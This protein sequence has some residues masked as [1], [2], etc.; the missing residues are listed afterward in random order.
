MKKVLLLTAISIGLSSHAMADTPYGLTPEDAKPL[1]SMLMFLSEDEMAD[2]MWFTYTMPATANGRPA[3]FPSTS[4]NANDHVMFI[5]TCADGSNEAPQMTPGSNGYVLEPGKEYLVKLTNNLTIPFLGMF[6]GLELPASKEGEEYFPKTAAM[7]LTNTQA[8]GTTVWYKLD[9]P[10]PS[11][12]TTNF[13]MMPVMDIEKVVTKHLACP[14]GVNEGNFIAPAYVKAGE[15]LIGITTSASATADVDFQLGLNGMVTL[16]CSNNLARSQSLQLDVEN[17][18]PDAYYTVERFFEV[19]E[20]DMYTFTNHGAPGTEL[21]IGV[22]NKIDVPESSLGYKYECDFS[23]ADSDV[24]G[25]N[26]ATVVKSLTKGDLVAVQS[27]AFAKLGDNTTYIKITR[28]DNSGIEG[29]VAESNQFSAIAL[30]GGKVSVNSKLLA[31]GAEVALFD[32]SARKVASTTVA[33]GAETRVVNINVPAGIYM[34]V[35]YG[36]SHS[37]TAKLVVK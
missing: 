9:V 30:G 25:D 18:Y 14:G 17:G 13:M 10:Y 28:G 29:V 32:M 26:D 11:S 8:P 36:N 27:D 33:A 16:N 31:A 6:S 12:V 15:N 7:G 34:I 4:P 1:P 37:E 19:P 22:V 24:V 35:V 23:N 3:L 5:Y 21:N 20:T 2:E